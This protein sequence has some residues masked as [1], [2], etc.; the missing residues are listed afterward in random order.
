MSAAAAFVMPSALALALAFAIDRLFGELPARA[1]PVVWM[2]RV[3]HAL[4]RR[5][6]ASGP[7]RQLVYGAGL[8]L[9]VPLG[10]AALGGAA[11]AACGEGPLRLPVEVLLLTST[12]AVGMLG[13]AARGLQRALDRGEL[14]AARAGLRN[15]CSRDPSAL[16]PHELAAAAIESTAEN[17]SDSIVAPLFYYVGFGLPGALAY[18]AINTLDAMVGYRGRFEYLGKAS[19][20]LDDL[21]NLIPA[22]LCALLLLLAG[23]VHGAR[24]R[25]G[26]RTWRADRRKT[27]SPNAGHP[28]AAMAGLL[29]VRLEKQGSYVLGAGLRAAEPADI[30]RA[31]RIMNGAAWLALGLALA[32]S[33]ELSDG[34]L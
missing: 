33:L 3:A 23:A 20:R 21:L 19:A 4:V 31:V 6:P 15:L 18:R 9:V 26:L 16:A 32:L 10:F 17:S 12:F 13:D 2:G 25:D 29:G 5:A 27:E 30:G 34:R 22:R 1:H 14:E 11:L 24:I 8:A 7:R 28:M